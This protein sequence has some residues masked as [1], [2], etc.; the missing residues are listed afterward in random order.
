LI[1][2]ERTDSIETELEIIFGPT[3][4]E[5]TNK[6]FFPSRKFT[7]FQCQEALSMSVPSFRQKS[8]TTGPDAGNP[9]KKQSYEEYPPYLRY[10]ILDLNDLNLNESERI[11]YQERSGYFPAGI[12]PK[13]LKIPPVKL[14]AAYQKLKMAPPTSGP[15]GIVFFQTGGRINM[16]QAKDTAFVHRN[17]NWLMTIVIHWKVGEENARVNGNNVVDSALKW[18]DSLYEIMESSTTGAYQNFPDPSLSGYMKAYYGE[19]Q[20]ML[21]EVKKKFDP[22]GLFNFPQMIT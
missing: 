12:P 19:N 7:Y 20:D 15:N 13:E 9:S 17:N 11:C 10:E 8:L 5:A 21:K 14:Q 4:K 18:Q 16:L 22:Y 1:Q 6:W 2:T 3:Y